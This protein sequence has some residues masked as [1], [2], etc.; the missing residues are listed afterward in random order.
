M[1]KS[2]LSTFV[3]DCRTDDIEAAAQFWGQA[4]GREVKVPAK[5]ADPYRDLSAMPSEPL[6][7]VQK[8]A[9][10]SRIH[11]DIESDDIEAEVARLTQLGAR[12]IEKFTPGP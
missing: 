5:Q 9:H 1:H 11:L 10:D 4:L 12:A 3:I 7:M 2:K 6:L 8:V